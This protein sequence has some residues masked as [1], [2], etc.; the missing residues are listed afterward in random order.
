MSYQ[1]YPNEIIE[2]KCTE[3][4]PAQHNTMSSLM[5]RR[6]R[7]MMSKVIEEAAVLDT[8]DRCL[9]MLAKSGMEHTAALAVLE[10]HFSRM[11]PQAAER[12]REIVDAYAQKAADKVRRW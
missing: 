6:T 9:A 7:A 10:A 4:V 12:Y 3:I 11:T 1:R 8:H 5:P 2:V